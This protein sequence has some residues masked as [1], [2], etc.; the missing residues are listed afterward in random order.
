VVN[1]EVMFSLTVRAAVD[2]LVI[3]EWAVILPLISESAVILSER[4]K[5]IVEI[6]TLIR[7]THV[8]VALVGI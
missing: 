7:S 2:Q 8:P 5:I 6:L 1:P 4:H 3:S